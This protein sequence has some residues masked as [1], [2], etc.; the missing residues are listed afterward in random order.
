MALLEK[1]IG[2]VSDN[3]ETSPADKIP[4]AVLIG[5]MEREGVLSV[6]LTERAEHLRNHAGQ[7]SFPG[8]RIEEGE[9]PTQTALRETHEE[10][11]LPSEAVKILGYLPSVVTIKGFHIVPVLGLIEGAPPLAPSTSEVNRILIEP[12]EPM[13]VASNHKEIERSYNNKRYSSWVISHPSE[14][15]WGATARLIVQWSRL[16]E[17]EKDA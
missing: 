11:A 16:I 5:L 17:E 1:I 15:I 7:I 6:I 13:L 14:Y 4:S 3:P 2:V 8:G 9:K 12:I 10:I